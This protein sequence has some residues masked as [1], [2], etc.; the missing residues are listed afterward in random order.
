M[1]MTTFVFNIIV[2][3]LLTS[4][5]LLL[6]F[7]S[8]YNGNARDT[9]QAIIMGTVAFIT[10]VATIFTLPSLSLRSN[11]IGYFLF[12]LCS[13]GWGSYMVLLTIDL[14]SLYIS[15]SSGLESIL[16]IVTL[17]AALLGLTQT[18]LNG[19]TWWKLP[20]S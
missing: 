18:I 13:L 1:R 3:C 17:P 8:S 20:R 10:I 4:V 15:P 7:Y 2:S 16:F 5:A 9:T 6:L 12:I 14:G 11:K 19:A